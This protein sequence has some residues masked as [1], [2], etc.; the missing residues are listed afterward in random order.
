MIQDRPYRFLLPRKL[1][2]R[3][4]SIAV[5]AVVAA[6]SLEPSIANASS[7]AASPG[8]NA[9][10]IAM[11]NQDATAR[12][13]ASRPSTCDAVRADDWREAMTHGVSTVDVR[14]AGPSGF[15]GLAATA[16]TRIRDLRALLSII[17]LQIVV[18]VGVLTGSS[19]RW[20][21]MWGADRSSPITAPRRRA[22]HTPPSR[23]IAAC[24]AA[25]VR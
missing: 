14:G 8:T 17:A 4:P 1:R 12:V 24:A 13:P 20:N 15:A 22:A 21:S 7:G 5:L 18:G 25:R 19:R 16:R 10:S 9:P 2:H 3:L 11:S 6:A 23:V